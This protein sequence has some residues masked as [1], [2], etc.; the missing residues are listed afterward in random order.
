MKK[1]YSEPLIFGG[2]SGEPFLKNNHVFGMAPPPSPFWDVFKWFGLPAQKYVFVHRLT[3]PGRNFGAVYGA[4]P[5]RRFGNLE[6]LLENFLKSYN[7]ATSA[8]GNFFVTRG[9]W[10]LP[11]FIHGLAAGV[12]ARGCFFGGWVLRAALPQP[13][14]KF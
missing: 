14:E 1:N 9:S 10:L 4:H 12:A 11:P 2:G 5:T 13:F 8:C 6:H 3:A 7:S